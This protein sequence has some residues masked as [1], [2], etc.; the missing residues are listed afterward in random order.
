[1]RRSEFDRAVA[2]EFGARGGS[3]LSDLI[4]SAVGGRTSA[5]ALAAGVDPREVWLALCEETDVADDRR[6]GVGRLEPRRS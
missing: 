5:D 2:D 1:M 6:Y 3:L 4:L